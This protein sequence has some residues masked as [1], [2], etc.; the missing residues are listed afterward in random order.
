MPEGGVCGVGGG[1]G[2]GVC[3]VG[4]GVCGV[5]GGGG[6]GVGVGVGG[7]VCGVGGGGVGVGVGGGGSDQM[8]VRVRRS[9]ARVLPG[10]ARAGI[11]CLTR[12]GLARVAGHRPAL[13]V[14]GCGCGGANEP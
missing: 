12:R 7:G 13:A 6:G 5:G 8:P 2:G 3:G 14:S 9:R 4:G 11:R 10:S 1:V